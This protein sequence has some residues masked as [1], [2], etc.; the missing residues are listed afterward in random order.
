M[1]TTNKEMNDSVWWVNLIFFFKD[2][3]KKKDVP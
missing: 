1:K 2:S 3:F